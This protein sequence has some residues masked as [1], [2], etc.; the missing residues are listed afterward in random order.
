MISKR[1][2]VSGRV[3]GVGFRYFVERK[4]Q[5]LGVAGYVRNLPNGKLEVEVEGDDVAVE[6]LVDF[7]RVGPT[8]AL[9]DRVEAHSQPIV[10]YTYFGVR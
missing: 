2:V 8:R 5:E 10:G 7:C 3:Q 4:A 1:I 6:T 9:V